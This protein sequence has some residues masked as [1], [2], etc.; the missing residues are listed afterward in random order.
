M[1]ALDLKQY[2]LSIAFC[3]APHCELQYQLLFLLW[4]LL[5]G[6]RTSFRAPQLLPALGTVASCWLPE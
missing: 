1:L 3:L 6:V 2:L 4:S 5:R